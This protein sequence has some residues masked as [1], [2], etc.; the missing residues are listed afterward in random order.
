MNTTKISR[1]YKEYRDFI[2]NSGLQQKDSQERIAKTI[3]EGIAEGRPVIAEGGT[4]NG[5]TVAYLLPAIE[6]LHNDPETDPEKQ[7]KLVISTSTIALQNQLVAGQAP[8]DKPEIPRVFD[9]MRKKYGKAFKINMSDVAVVVGARQHLCEESEAFPRD[10]GKTNSTKEILIGAIGEENYIKLN[11]TV[12]KARAEKKPILLRELDNRGIEKLPPSII[13]E[14][15]CR[16]SNGCKCFGTSE[17]TCSFAKKMEKVKDARIIITNHSM[18][19]MNYA[20][21]RLGSIIVVDEANK[22][23]DVLTRTANAEVQMSRIRRNADEFL[24][25][26]SQ[27]SIMTDLQDKIDNARNFTLKLRAVIDTMEKAV[28][29]ECVN[30]KDNTVAI[31][32]DS[33]E[34][35]DE[36]NFYKFMGDAFPEGSREALEAGR[37]SYE[38]LISAI[39]L[40]YM[41]SADD[42]QSQKKVSAA[43]HGE[44]MDMLRVVERLTRGTGDL[45]SFGRRVLRDNWLRSNEKYKKNAHDRLKADNILWFEKGARSIS[46][47]STPVDHVTVQQQAAKILFNRSGVTPTFIS[48]SLSTSAQKPDFVN[49]RRAL[50]IEN[51]DRLNKPALE[52]LEKS[53][54]K[55]S[56]QSLLII[57]NDL[58][59]P[60]YKK[61]SPTEQSTATKNYF[62][63]IGNDI[64]RNAKLITG[65]SMVLCS[66][67]FQVEYLADY[68]ESH[69]DPEKFQ[70]LTVDGSTSPEKQLQKMRQGIE[71][72]KILLG[73]DTLWNGVDLKGEALRGLFILK[74]PFSVPSHPVEKVRKAKWPALHNRSYF[75]DVSLPAALDKMRQGIGR[76]I[77]SE[78]VA[79]EYGVIV[80]YDPRFS[81][82]IDTQKRKRFIPAI[83]NS[84]PKGM[85]LVFSKYN[86][87]PK[88]VADFFE[89]H[90]NPQPALTEMLEKVDEGISLEDD[91]AIARF[92]QELG[93]SGIGM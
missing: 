67:L 51:W 86:D 83:L 19:T 62:D 66:S 74:V 33:G 46:M 48:A 61:T 36:L 89:E 81:E 80:F 39:K 77:R 34:I 13:D 20:I 1:P 57:P 49:F 84:F 63:A 60:D 9:A 15:S 28:A 35:I 72:K 52:I 29:A 70:I 24:K 82:S 56:E 93:I 87:I 43:R 45:Y 78:D 4:G 73:R 22:L 2:E 85:P 69:L 26:T 54:H 12:K 58:P 23:A 41:G 14:I 44:Y 47:L 17:K 79:N 18:L 11:Q 3:R 31:F 50:G 92:E 37:K 76:L 6:A 55:Y 68:L 8:G 10:D 32:D 64:A 75:A 7:K 88:H 90:T 91:E 53:E 71:P 65:N 5:K 30:K 38:N 59:L 16:G 21:S 40:A 27:M 42:S 25:L